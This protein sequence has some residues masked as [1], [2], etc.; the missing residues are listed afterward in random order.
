MTRK[1]LFIKSQVMLPNDFSGDISDALVILAR[2]CRT[3]A[4]LKANPIVSSD[5]RME[6][7]ASFGKALV[8]EGTVRFYSSANILT[9][10]F[11][12][13]SLNDADPVDFRVVDVAEVPLKKLN[14]NKPIEG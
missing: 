1:M 11:E 6:I 12:R 3:E 2:S 8:K 9:L 5:R 7:A 10:E 14:V 13:E 4:F